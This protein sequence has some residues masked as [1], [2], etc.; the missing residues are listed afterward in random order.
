[1]NSKRR[2][3]ILLPVFSLPSRYGIGCFDSAAYR[4]VDFLSTAGQSEWQ[5]LPLGPTGY[6]DSPYQS[7]SSYAGNPYFVSLEAL[8]ADGFLSE[9]ECEDAELEGGDRR[10]DYGV[11]YTRRLPLLRLAFERFFTGGNDEFNSFCKNNPRVME[12][13]FFMALKD[14]H[15][16]TPWNEWERGVRFREPSALAEARE[17]LAREISFYAF[18]QYRFFSDFERLHAYARERGISLIGD[19]PIYVSYDSADVWA[20]PE[21]FQ[22]DAELLPTAVAGC[23]PDGFSPSGQLWGNPLYRWEAHEKEGYAWWVSRISEAKRRCDTLRIDHFRGFD[24]YYAIPYGAPDARQGRWEKGPG[25]ALFEALEAS[26]GGLDIIVE[27]L[28]FID[29][30]VRALVKATGFPNM[31]VLEFGFD[32]RDDLPDGEHLPHNYPDRCV[33]YLG[34]HDNETAVGW[35][36]GLGEHERRLLLEYLAMEEAELPT[37]RNALLALL[38]RSPAERCIVTAQD[39]LGLDD[40]ARINQPS[41]VGANW[42]W[43]VRHGELSEALGARILRMTSL[44]G[45]RNRKE[46]E[47]T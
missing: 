37:V 24:A 3:G 30:S 28:G 47:K 33:A 11:Q 36:R 16:G 41:T 29:D 27:D 17:T 1:M 46:E 26:C 25:I 43:R 12:Y 40:R 13:A 4:F 8:V 23:P 18:V 20:S 7:F 38:L 35:L 6:G 19:L 45:R 14:R 39:W 22:L 21:H 15:G 2:A 34:T 32:P 42:R 31:R 9:Q 44:Y 10:V 5:I